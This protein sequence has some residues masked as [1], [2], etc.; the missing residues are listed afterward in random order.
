L[1]T[2]ESLDFP[3]VMYMAD[4]PA[5]RDTVKRRFPIFMS[6]EDER[7]ALFG[8]G[9]EVYARRIAPSALTAYRERY[10]EANSAA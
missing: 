5:V 7:E 4:I 1:R 8:A 6:T 3:V 2:Y 9:D 10:R